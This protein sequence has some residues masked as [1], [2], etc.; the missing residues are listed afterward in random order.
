MAFTR[1]NDLL[2][3]IGHRVAGD[4]LEAGLCEGFLPAST[5][6]P[7]SRTTSGSLSAVSFAASTMPVGDDVAIHDAAENVHQDPL[8]VRVARG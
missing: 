1:R 3:G 2:R 7:S 5:L 4:D 6:F 8:H